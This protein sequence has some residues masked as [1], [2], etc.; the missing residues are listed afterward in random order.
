MLFKPATQ[1]K[2]MLKTPLI[3]SIE[4]VA[5]KDDDSDT[6][7]EVEVRRLMYERI[8]QGNTLAEAEENARC[9]WYS[10]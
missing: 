6:I 8:A 9:R 1:E 2:R 5:N 4:T 7:Q 3:E 10:R